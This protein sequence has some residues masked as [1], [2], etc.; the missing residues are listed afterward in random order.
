VKK[1]GLSGEES[2]N[3]IEEKRTRREIK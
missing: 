3:N 2:G 1:E